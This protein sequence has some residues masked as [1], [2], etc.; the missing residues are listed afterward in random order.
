MA[1]LALVD[2]G[3][4]VA[5]LDRN[6]PWHRWACDEIRHLT[7]PLLTCEPVLS[8]AAHLI[9]HFDPSAR[10][11]HD[12][13]RSDGLRL[14]FDLND[15]LDAVANLMVKYEDIPMSL[16]D[17]CMVRMSEL[18]DRSRV[19]TVDSDFRLYRRHS[20]QT[21]PLILPAK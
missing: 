6:D 17:A 5:F 1:V 21:I 20:R 9:A 12:L 3:P 14:A 7:E 10:R 8:E 13:L 2:T 11:L 18:Y 16:A 19:F 15:H 4:L